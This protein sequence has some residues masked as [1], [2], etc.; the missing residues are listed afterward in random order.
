MEA[1]SPTQD[2]GQRD[3]SSSISALSLAVHTNT[4]KKTRVTS[5]RTN[6]GARSWP[7]SK[8]GGIGGIE[9]KARFEEDRET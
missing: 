9:V 5:L 2:L 1:I 3:H 4:Q 8:P 6:E 7:P